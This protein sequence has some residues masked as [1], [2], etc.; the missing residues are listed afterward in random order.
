MR[1]RQNKPDAPNPAVA[2]QFQV[3]RLG[4]GVDDPGR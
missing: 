1:T 4:R 2:L 3:E